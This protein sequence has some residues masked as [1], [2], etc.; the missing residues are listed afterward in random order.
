MVTWGTIQIIINQQS[1]L[2]MQKSAFR[3]K[4][5]PPST[6]SFVCF[7]H[8]YATV[9]LRAARLTEEYMFCQKQSFSPVHG[10]HLS[11]FCRTPCVCLPLPTQVVATTVV[12]PPTSG[13]TLGH[14]DFIKDGQISKHCIACDR[15][16]QCIFHPAES[17]EDTLG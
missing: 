3:R 4:W 6:E 17:Q 10:T 1:N 13:A 14:C 16:G 11:L 15:A 12:R 8:I 9:V 7:S 2:E 5:G